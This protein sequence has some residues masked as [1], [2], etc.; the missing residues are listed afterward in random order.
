LNRTDVNE[1][2][3]NLPPKKTELGDPSKSGGAA[4]YA[5]GTIWSSEQDAVRAAGRYAESLKHGLTKVEVGG[6]I[7]QTEDGYSFN[8]TTSYRQGEIRNSDLES[9]R[10]EGAVAIWHTH[11]FLPQNNGHGEDFS[12][13]SGDK[14]VSKHYNMPVYMYSPT[15]RIYSFKHKG[16]RYEDKVIVTHGLKR[17]TRVL[18]PY[19]VQKEYKNV[20]PK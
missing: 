8:I 5:P 19:G 2:S 14:G 20:E 16:Y 9:I 7:Y 6:W 3:S 15:R 18:V 12:D 1:K 4:I 11:N 10:I 13:Y 17:T